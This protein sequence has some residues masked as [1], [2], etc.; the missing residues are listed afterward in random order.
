MRYIVSLIA[1]A[2]LMPQISFAFEDTS[3][4]DLQI[5]A[6]QALI[7]EVQEEIN[8][9]NQNSLKEPAKSVDVSDPN[10][11]LIEIFRTYLGD[12]AAEDFAYFLDKENID[13]RK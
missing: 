1:V 12:A 9:L 3:D 6:V 2:L 11:V 13:L 10:S 5:R 4:V 8:A 7:Y